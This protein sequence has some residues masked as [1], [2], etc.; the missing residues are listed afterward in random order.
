VGR[1]RLLCQLDF[2]P[3]TA[4]C[5]TAASL[6][7]RSRSVKARGFLEDPVGFHGDAFSHELS[8]PC[9]SGA[10]R[11]IRDFSQ[12]VPERDISPGYGI[13]HRALE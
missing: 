10:D 11:S 13:E 5:C 4:W 7:A 9:P 2:P 3:L 8:P 12:E 1:Q 6:V